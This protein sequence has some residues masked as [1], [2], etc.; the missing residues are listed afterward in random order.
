M[1][2]LGLSPQSGQ[3]CSGTKHVLCWTGPVARLRGG[4]GLARYYDTYD[5]QPVSD[6]ADFALQSPTQLLSTTREPQRP[7]LSLEVPGVRALKSQK[8]QGQ[9]S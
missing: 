1:L 2:F 3:Y 9:V 8:V 4:G 5:W 6:P 7:S